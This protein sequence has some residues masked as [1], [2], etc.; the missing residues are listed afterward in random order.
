MA[1]P[2]FLHLN[3]Q[4]AQRLG[5]EGAE[6]NWVLGVIESLNFIAHPKHFVLDKRG[7]IS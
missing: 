1:F 4:A 5:I 6:Q 3:D 2:A 7:Q